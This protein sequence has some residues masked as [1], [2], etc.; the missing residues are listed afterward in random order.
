MSTI[1]L[2]QRPFMP[3]ITVI[4]ALL[5]AL[6]RPGIIRAADPLP[7]MP[8]AVELST[9][10]T[11]QD[12]A[13]APQTGD[14]V[15]QTAFTATG[16]YPATVPGTVL[17]T[18][19]NNKVYPEPLYG[20][21]NRTTIIPD[22]LCRT[23]YW[24]RN[25]FTVPASYAERHVWLNFDGI[26][27]K[28]IVW[29]NGHKVGQID[30]AFTRGVFEITSLVTPGKDAALAVEI[31]P[32]PD[33]GTPLE[34]TVANGTGANGGILTKDG[35]TFLCTLGWD[36]IPGIRDRDMGIWQKVFLSSTGS[37]VIKDPLVT[38]DLPLPRTDSADLT[39]QATV[40]NVDAVARRGTFQAEL[41]GVAFTAPVDLQ[42][43]ESTTLKFDKNNT[44]SL[45]INNPKLWWPN[46]YGPQNLETFHLG[47]FPYGA[48]SD[49]KDVQFGIR[50]ITYDV[51]D[52]DNLT[53]T[54]NGVK[55]MCKGG[56]WGMDEAMK[57]NPRPRLEAQIRMHALANYNMIRNWVGQST[58]ED[59]YELCDKYG[60]MLWDEF[61][62]PNPSDG[63]NIPETADN[64]EV[65][66]YLANVREKVLRFRNHPSIALWCGRNEGNPAPASVLEGIQ[67]IMKELEP[68]R[69]FQASSTDGGG[70][71]S[72]GP[73]SWRTPADYFNYPDTE[74]FKTELGSV[75]IPTVEAV[76]NMMPAKD[77]ENLTPALNDDWAEHDLCFGAQSPKTRMYPTTIAA[78]YGAWTG[79]QQFVRE[80]QLANYEAYRALYEGRFAYMFR[81]CTGVLTW[82]SN[83]SQP[84]MVWQLYSYDLEPNASLFAT[85]KA[86]ESVHIQLDQDD[87]SM[88]IINNTP[89]LLN[90]LKAWIRVIN[91]DSTVA[92]DRQFPVR[93]LPTAATNIGTITWPD[94]GKLSPVY[95]VKLVL[96]DGDNKVLSDNFYW[97]SQ[98]S[99]I[100]DFTSLQTLPPVKLDASIARH[101]AD[102]KCLLD[103]TLHNPT[104]T[105]ALMAHVQLRRQNSNDRV[106]PVYYTDNYVSLIPG[107]STTFIVEAAAADLHGQ[108][109]L[110]VLDGWNT[111][112]DAASFTS[113]G[114]CAIAP[115]M[116]AIVP[117]ATQP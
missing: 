29:V 108:N 77:W 1:P 88:N 109:P 23:S 78:R 76:Q 18:L 81:P 33:P 39:L 86:C 41:D 102:G 15:S 26:N 10:W 117:P 31:L 103:V 58:S 66:M 85:R 71:K 35:P 53:L 115:N 55:I 64:N 11:L 73:Y 56:D 21:N 7:P 19:V 42:P 54:V 68:T 97:Q 20:E 38:S 87:M 37:F 46:G 96:L 92:Y 65:P 82:M 28:A 43:G 5:A 83:P 24:Y 57:R 6:S 13:K 101:D 14:A 107:E 106:L 89:K 16:W 111:T 32:P 44:P 69:Y 22:S 30:G 70:V 9:G 112:A 91:L 114:P 50:K 47:V 72:G 104:K 93:A 12:E 4:L 61:F 8:A 51:P 98:A 34:Q 25:A 36:W 49:I 40:Q 79:L 94:A 95:F 52:S 27:Y 84:S 67:A 3:F 90:G 80:S 2:T 113:G 17:T 48:S 45:H 62:Q 99:H 110:L 59:F 74:A 63:P 75:S 105:V 60:I 100:T 116:N